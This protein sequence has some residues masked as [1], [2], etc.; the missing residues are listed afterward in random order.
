MLTETDAGQKCLLTN[1]TNE[2]TKL[3]T[4][5]LDLINTEK[6]LGNSHDISRLKLIG[7]NLSSVTAQNNIRV[8]YKTKQQIQPNY[9][10]IKLNME[11]YNQH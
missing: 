5:A 9:K 7:S 2:A 6:A 4:K 1:K 3:F 8:T 11:N 10:T